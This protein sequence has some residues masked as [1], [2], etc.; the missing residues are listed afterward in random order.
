MKL[1]LR[2][3]LLVGFFSLIALTML[4]QIYMLA[5]AVKNS[6]SLGQ[7][8]SDN[9]ILL[10][11]EIAAAF[12]ISFLLDRSV[13]KSIN[14]LRQIMESAGAGDLTVH[15]KI[16]THDEFGDLAKSFNT[17]IESQD[18]IVREVSSASEQ[19]AASAQEMSASTEEV[20]ASFEEVS[21]SMQGLASETEKGN[22]AVLEASQ[23]LVQ[24]SSLI[25]MAKLKSGTTANDSLETKA[26]AESGLTNV[27]KTIETM[28]TIKNQT[29][30]TSDM[31][32]D[33][34]NYSQQIRQIIDTI[35]S[36]AS[37]TNLLALNAAIEAARAGEHGK[38]FSVVAEEVRKLAE[39]SN[40]GAQE[41][42][43][44]I[45][46]VSQ[47]TTQVVSAMAENSSQVEAGVAAVNETGST[48]DKI[49]QAI[50]HTVGE[51]STI[52][53]I[54]AEEVANSDQIVKLI[55]RL[56]SIIE[57]VEHHA[58]EIA[59]ATEQQTAA[60]Q[61]IAGCSEETA[62]MSGSLNNT[63]GHFKL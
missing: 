28:T 19:L 1:T 5:T 16:E 25:Q 53:G 41:I 37:Q 44:L 20:T 13:I 59:S 56:A 8:L 7:L 63:I 12:I 4:G 46:N 40:Q 57:A 62:A 15:S 49:L 34:D 30:I 38:G 60:M 23:A 3:K 21:A 55:D 6:A 22:K 33:L 58:E 51:I 27:H 45:E 29:Q 35:T 11:I 50:D 26:A 36:I 48:L 9:I 52:T 43:H 10:I 31:I 17:M 39:Q 18:K 54:A 42:T 24:L 47:K 2:M 61:N 14:S 32:T